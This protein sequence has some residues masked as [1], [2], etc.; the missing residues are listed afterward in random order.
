ML[1]ASPHPEVY[2]MGTE[3]ERKFLVDRAI[4]KP[5]EEGTLTRQGYLSSLKERV[6]RVRIAGPRAYLT[7]KGL[8]DDALVRLEFE[9]PLPLGDASQLLD[10]VCEKPLVEKTR[11]KETI[12]AHIW[13][14]DIFHGD[15][16]GLVVAEIELS[17][18]NESF[19][20][21]AWLGIE[22]SDDPRYLNANLARAPF[23][24]WA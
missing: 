8:T 6:V 7:I 1:N 16:D 23:K 24:S 3:I 14:V 22:V 10:R 12:G 21:P 17:D 5:V 15:N 19:E 4:W 9:Y 13:E 2:R 20:R 11:Y 18:P